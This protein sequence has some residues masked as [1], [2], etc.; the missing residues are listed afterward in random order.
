MGFDVIAHPKSGTHEIKQV[1]RQPNE[2]D[3]KEEAVFSVAKLSTSNSGITEKTKAFL[4][5]I[6]GTTTPISFVRDIL[7]PYASKNVSVIF[8]KSWDSQ[9]KESID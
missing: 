9:I 3:G 4:F 6:R 1:P 5:D 2:R 7:F 8:R